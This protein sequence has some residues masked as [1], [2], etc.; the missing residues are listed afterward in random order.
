MES[1]FKEFI[2]SKT[3][4]GIILMVAGYF[5]G[6]EASAIT[7]G[8]SPDMINMVT[9][10]LIS[11]GGGLATFGG[12]RR[13]KKTKDLV[14]L[15]DEQSKIIDNAQNQLQLAR[16]EVDSLKTLPPSVES[17]AK[18]MSAHARAKRKEKTR[19]PLA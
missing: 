10:I 1:H 18:V 15:I 6:D 3:F 19:N 11:L 16:K 14:G 13:V 5:F 12:W 4:A 7:L 9:T 8:S 17:A 2:V